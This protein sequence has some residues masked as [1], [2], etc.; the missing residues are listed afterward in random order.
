MNNTFET[1]N[2]SADKMVNIDPS[3]DVIF[4]FV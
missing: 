3:N 1:I 2:E 4:N